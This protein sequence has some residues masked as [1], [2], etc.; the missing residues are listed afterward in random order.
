MSNHISRM[1]LLAAAMIAAACGSDPQPATSGAVAGKA[2]V[3]NPTTAAGT[4]A[5][6]TVKSAVCGDGVVSGAEVCDGAALGAATCTSLMYGQGVL[7]CS[8]S[9]ATF[10]LTGCTGLPGGGGGTGA[11]GTS[12]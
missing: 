5:G 12:G 7:K 8:A 9:C 2:S 3:S 11:G 10:D 4:S 1:T 6:S